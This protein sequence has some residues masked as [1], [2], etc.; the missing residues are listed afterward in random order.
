MK[1]QIDPWAEIAGLIALEKKAALA[2][3]RAREFAPGVLPARRSVPT[4]EQRPVLR[5]TVLALA[6]SILFAAGLT[7]LWLLKGSWGSISSEPVLAGLLS[8]TYLYH[9]SGSG[10][11]AASATVAKAPVN[12]H[13]AAWIEVGLGRTASEAEAVDP[14]APV[15]R[16]DPLEVRRK[17]SRMI[18]EDALE[19]LLTQ[20]RGIHE[21]EA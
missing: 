16:G 9:R 8:D 19:R 13:F 4:A 6:A 21:K 18:R 5:R 14:Q 11:A 10:E 3:F 7:A 20:F 12:P 17:L 15:E 2:D 1:K